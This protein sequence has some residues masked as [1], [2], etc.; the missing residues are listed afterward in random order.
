MKFIA[1]HPAHD[2][3]WWADALYMVM[4]VMTKMYRLTGDEMY[5][6]K[7]YENVLYSDSI[8]LDKGNRALL[9]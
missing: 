5:L 7:L 1:V 8:M 4:P 9:P 2:Y 3:W 6:D